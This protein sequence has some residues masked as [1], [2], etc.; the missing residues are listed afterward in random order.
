[1]APETVEAISEPQTVEAISEPQA[2]E[3]IS[4]PRTVEPILQPRAVEP[5]SDQPVSADGLGLDEPTDAERAQFHA[6]IQAFRQ[7]QGMTD[8]QASIEV[9]TTGTV[10]DDEYWEQ[11]RKERQERLER[12]DQ[13]Q[14]ER[15]EEQARRYET[16]HG[17]N[18]DRPEPDPGVHDPPA[19]GEAGRPPPGDGAA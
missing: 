3:P 5:I 6:M 9:M 4:Q 1:V 2:V 18:A 7:A 12:L 14:R 13:E 10:P 17:T 15:R 19:A 16:F 11:R 8:D